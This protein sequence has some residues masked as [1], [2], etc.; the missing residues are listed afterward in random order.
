MF[1][2]LRSYYFSRYG[3]AE[4]LVTEMKAYEPEAARA[5]LAETSRKEMESI[6]E[7]RIG[8]LLRKVRVHF[9][10]PEYPPNAEVTGEP[11]LELDGTPGEQVGENGYFVRP[12]VLLTDGQLN[13]YYGFINSPI[14]SDG[15]VIQRHYPP[16]TK[17][18]IGKSSASN[19]KKTRLFV[20]ACT[21]TTLTPLK[22]ARRTGESDRA[23]VIPDLDL[24]RLITYL[25]LYVDLQPGLPDPTL[26]ETNDEGKP[27]L[28]Q[29]EGTFPNA[30]PAWAFGTLGVVAGIGSW[31]R[32]N[33]FFADAEPVL[34][35]LAGG[36]SYVIDTSGDNRVETAGS[37]VVGLARKGVLHRALDRAWRV[38]TDANEE[39]FYR[40]LRRW[41]LRFRRAQFRDFLSIRALYP[42]S[43]S[44]L[45]D[46]YFMQTYDE[47]LIGSAR[48]AGQ[49]VNDQAYHAAEGSTQEAKREDKQTILASIESMLYDCSNGPEMIARLSTQVGRL[50]GADFPPE[51]RGFFDR[52]TSGGLSVEDAR[53]LLVAYMRLRSAPSTGEDAGS[54][55]EATD[56]DKVDDDKVESGS[57]EAT[58]EPESGASFDPDQE[59]SEM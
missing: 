55:A 6:F 17:L 37:H 4:V 22:A 20:L 2:D 57:S 23:A 39:D 25:D 19:V 12:T 49:H 24:P 51:A 50:T 3:L 56:A 58:P 11:V 59:L 54:S 29:N 1:D 10:S 8:R 32:E 30:P 27:F 41:L 35:A 34:E 36:R 26:A 40:E 42:P 46:A 18:S 5:A 31:A 43:F 53:N 45:I 15:E 47:K 44:P 7:K 14:P 21:V 28:K 38:E 33:G 48:A 52:T 9:P 16:A 13:G